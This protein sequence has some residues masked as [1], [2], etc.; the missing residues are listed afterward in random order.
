MYIRKGKLLK[1]TLCIHVDPDIKSMVVQRACICAPFFQSLSSDFK[2]IVLLH[3]EDSNHRI[4][5]MVYLPLNNMYKVVRFVVLLQN[6]LH[7][8]SSIMDAKD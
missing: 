4:K 1:F 7:V 8:N 3:N 6:N 5:L 2:N